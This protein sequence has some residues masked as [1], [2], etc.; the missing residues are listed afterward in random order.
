MCLIR[1]K[2]EFRGNQS[3]LEQIYWDRSHIKNKRKHISQI[4]VFLSNARRLRARNNVLIT[5]GGFKKKKKKCALCSD[6][7]RLRALWGYR[8]QRSLYARR[9]T[10]ASLQL[11]IVPFPPYPPIFRTYR[12]VSLYKYIYTYALYVVIRLHIPTAACS[13]IGSRFARRPR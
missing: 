5:R 1:G 7:V 13:R 9:C 4:R 10:S 12:A 3:H 6:S 8:Q 2:I 11:F